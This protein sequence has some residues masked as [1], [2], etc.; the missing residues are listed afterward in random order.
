MDWMTTIGQLIN[1]TLVFSTALIFAALGGIFSERSGVINIGIEGLMTFGAFAAGVAT[2]YAENAGMGAASPYIGLLA[3]VVMGIIASLIHAVASITFKAD[4]V[5]SG[6]VI[7]FLAAG[8]TLYM[9]KLLFDGAGETPLLKEGLDKWAVPLLSKI[10][11][12]GEG[13]FN[14]YPTTYLAIILVLVSFYVL[15]K[16]SFGLRLRA[17]G[18]HPSAADTVGVKV[19]RMRYIGVIVSGALAALGGATITLTTTSTF[20]HN[21][22]SGQGFI[23]IAAMIFGKWNPLG[24]FGAAVFFGFSQA[25]GNYFQLFSWS[26]DI[27]QEFIYMLPYVLTVV[28]LVAAVGKSSAPAAL[29]EPYDPGKR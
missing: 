29:G 2:F 26:K 9:V 4:Q 8:S 10:P 21:T 28:V 7:N 14:N 17:V 3:A 23:A 15:Y 27:P 18:E 12:I 6:V 25:I 1:T 22:I 13:L 5:V 16:T 19:Q 24:A 20:S 11:I